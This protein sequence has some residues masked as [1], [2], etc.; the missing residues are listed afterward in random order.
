MHAPF[1]ENVG[2]GMLTNENGEKV[3]S[4]AKRIMQTLL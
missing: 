3:S 4:I 2:A 1:N